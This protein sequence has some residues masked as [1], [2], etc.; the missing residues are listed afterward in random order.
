MSR[1]PDRLP[2]GP[3]LGPTGVARQPVNSTTPSR[4]NCAGDLDVAWVLPGRAVAE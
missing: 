2:N 1:A 3:C 4:L